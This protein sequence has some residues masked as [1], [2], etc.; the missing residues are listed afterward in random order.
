MSWWRGVVGRVPEAGALSA[1]LRVET[2]WRTPGHGER[3][4]DG[5]KVYLDGGP[6]G[7]PHALWVGAFPPA[8]YREPAV[9]AGLE[10]TVVQGEVLRRAKILEASPRRLVAC[11]EYK[12]GRV[13]FTKRSNGIWREEGLRGEDAPRLVLGIGATNFRRFKQWYTDDEVRCGWKLG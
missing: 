6:P 5:R 1:E 4:Q 11:L 7:D 10:A 3:S 9:A 2:N 8:G 13:G 12:R